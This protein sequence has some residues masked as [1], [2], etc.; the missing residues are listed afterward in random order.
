MEVLFSAQKALQNTPKQ[1][2][3]NT[4]IGSEAKAND[5]KNIRQMG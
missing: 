2:L 3:K 4:L 5:Y 1:K